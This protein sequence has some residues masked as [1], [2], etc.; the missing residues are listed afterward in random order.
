MKY[1]T[2]TF[3]SYDSTDINNWLELKSR[4]GW[5]LFSVTKV[6]S[7]SVLLVMEKICS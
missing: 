1:V 2:M 5:K 7:N 3:G 6:G 4:E